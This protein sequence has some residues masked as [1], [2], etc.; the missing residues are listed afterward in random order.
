MLGHSSDSNITDKHYFEYA[1]NQ[2]RV[3]AVNDF[4]KFEGS[5]HAN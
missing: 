4:F 5:R 1:R 2:T 3:E